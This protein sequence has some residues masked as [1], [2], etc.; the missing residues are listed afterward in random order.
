MKNNQIQWRHED[1]G[2]E[3]G[4]VEGYAKEGHEQDEDDERYEG[5]EGHEGDEEHEDQE[6]RVG[7]STCKE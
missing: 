1:A 2:H 3:E 6:M 5:D 4:S 7:R